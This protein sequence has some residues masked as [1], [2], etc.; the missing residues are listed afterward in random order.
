MRLLLRGCLSA[1]VIIALP[2]SYVKTV[3]AQDVI[4]SSGRAIPEDN[5]AYPVLLSLQTIIGKSL[6]SGFFL[7]ATHAMY[8]I[9]ANHFL[10][11]LNP[12]LRDANTKEYRSDVNVSVTSYSR[13]LSDNK[14][15]SFI[16]NLRT[17]ESS[18]HLQPD[19]TTDIVV[20]TLGI[21]DSANKQTPTARTPVA[22][23]AVQ[24][25]AALGTVGV[26]I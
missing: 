6:A 4:T 11:E 18:G 10:A 19:P 23:V 1:L 5:L 13:D 12:V 8:L 25:M 22:G 20:I 26:S 7:N 14:H 16:L 15:N 17:L 3:A 24:E 9:T 2:P 21:G